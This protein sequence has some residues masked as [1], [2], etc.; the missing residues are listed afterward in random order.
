ML[1]VV[2]ATVED[3]LLQL[4]HR[5]GD[6]FRLL[7]VAG[8]RGGALQAGCEE[9][10]MPVRQP[11]GVRVH[12]AQRSDR[13]RF[14]AGLFQK[15]LPRRLLGRLPNLD[16][17]GG[18]FQRLAPDGRPVLLHGQQFAVG[19]HS[20]DRNVV[21]RNHDIVRVGGLVFRR[22]GDQFHPGR[23]EA[24]FVALVGIG[25][26]AHGRSDPLEN[27]LQRRRL[28]QARCRTGEKTNG[29]LAP[30]LAGG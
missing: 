18:E 16:V 30:T 26:D 11:A 13:S 19:E 3:E 10:P 6:D 23:R 12:D 24:D 22:N 21:F 14:V 15:L 2:E 8:A 4:F 17:P 1:C 7:A 9:A 27:E 20:H 29:T 5:Q 28:T 25:R